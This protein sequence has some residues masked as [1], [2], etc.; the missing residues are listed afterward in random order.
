MCNRNVTLPQNKK[1]GTVNTG[2]VRTIDI[3]PTIIHATGG[4]VP[5]AMQGVNLLAEDADALESAFSEEDHENNVITSL[6]TD[7][8]KLI[9]TEDGSPRMAAPIQL[10]D[11]EQD[12]AEQNN[13]AGDNPEVVRKMQ[14]QIEDL[15]G[16]ISGSAY[17][18]QEGEVDSATQDRLKALGYVE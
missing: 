8:W 16:H 12:P 13:L 4:A 7:Q 14:Q 10:F 11:M 18:A 17:Q 9:I 3:A 15:A 5:E 2:L 1:A 6:R